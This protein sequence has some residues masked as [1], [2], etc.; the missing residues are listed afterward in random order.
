MLWN[1]W[2]RR[3]KKAMAFLTKTK[4]TQCAGANSKSPGVQVG[5]RQIGTHV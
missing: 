3:A 1:Q 5:I 4:L 2:W